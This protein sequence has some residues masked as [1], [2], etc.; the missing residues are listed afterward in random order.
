MSKDHKA[1]RPKTESPTEK[2]TDSLPSR[3]AKARLLEAGSR[4]GVQGASGDCGQAV[5]HS[6]PFL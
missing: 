2:C 1:A 6:L 3:R 4:T 5:D